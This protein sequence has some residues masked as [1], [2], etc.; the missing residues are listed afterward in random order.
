[1]AY[2]GIVSTD[3]VELC[4]YECDRCG[5]HIGIDGSYLEQVKDCIVI[6]C[7]SCKKLLYIDEDSCVCYN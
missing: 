4:V 3:K 1:M 6:S 5:F 7:P 2:I